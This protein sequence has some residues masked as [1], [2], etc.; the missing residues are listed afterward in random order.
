MTKNLCE[1]RKKLLERNIE[2]IVSTLKEKYKPEKIILFGSI[3]SGQISLTSDIDLLII[4]KT[5]TGFYERLKE[6][7]TLCDYDV[8]IDFLVYTPEEFEEEAKSN[9]FFQKE[10]LEKGKVI[11]DAAA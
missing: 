7:I 1:S 10:V 3:V 5:N 2:S 6:V 11:Y 9:L 8:G 4:K